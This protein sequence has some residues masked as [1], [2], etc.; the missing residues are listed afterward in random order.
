MVLLKS[1]LSLLPLLLSFA[2][3][4]A[5]PSDLSV[6]APS[7]PGPPS[8]PPQPA[9]GDGI[10]P[11]NSKGAG[12]KDRL[13]KVKFFTIA[14]AAGE[15]GLTNAERGMRHYLGN[16]GDD[17]NVA[18]GPMMNDLPEFRKAAQ[19]LAQNEATKAYRAISAK[20]GSKAFSSKWDTY[21]AT[22][23]KSWD[24]FYAIGGFSFSV[25]GVVTKKSGGGSLKYQVH[26]FDRY[27]WDAGKSVTIGPF[28]F[29]DRELGE[30][31]L[32]GLAR[33]YVVR[34]SSQVNEVDSFKPGT[35]I[36]PPS[37]GGRN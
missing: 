2:S 15:I 31:H 34:G 14:A 11:Y 8:D 4:A 12:W 13:N 27:N 7:I 6:R 18:P 26:I 28:T 30:L 37:T 33:E 19:A 3:A 25:T 21:Y 36:P 16:S 24:W 20:S 29:E 17:L 32:K 23:E 35:V 1:A 9:D 5:L 10:G 22:K